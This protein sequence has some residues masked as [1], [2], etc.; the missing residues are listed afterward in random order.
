M[1]LAE[2]ADTVI[3]AKIIRTEG[4]YYTMR[5]KDLEKD[6]FSDTI[7]MKVSESYYK[8]DPIKNSDLLI[9]YTKLFSNG[10]RLD[11]LS[12][13]TFRVLKNGKIFTPFQIENPGK[14]GFYGPEKDSVTWSDFKKRI[15]SVNKRIKK[16]YNY[17]DIE[18]VSRKN[19]L[20]IHWIEQNQ[21]SFGQDCGWNDDC[22]WGFLEERVFR[23]ISK[24]NI[25]EDTWKA[26]E[27]Y[28]NIYFERQ[29]KTWASSGLMH[30]QDGSSFKAKEDKAFLI[31]KA[32]S[33]TVDLIERKQ[34]L[35]FLK[36]AKP[37]LHD[38]KTSILP[39]LRDSE[40][41]QLSIELINEPRSD[42]EEISLVLRSTMITE[43]HNATPGDFKNEIGKYLGRTC[44]EE[45][46][47]QISGSDVNLVLYLYSIRVDKNSNRLQFTLN[48]DYNNKTRD[49]R[50]LMEAYPTIIVESTHNAQEVFRK[51]L[52]NQKLKSWSAYFKVDIA[53]LAK[54]EYQFYLEGKAGDQAQYRW[55]SI[56][57]M[58]T[59]D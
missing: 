14:V 27:L 54:G 43:Y 57:G 6:V 4:E 55:K 23:W 9:V 3:E 45:A 51:K 15:V 58:F 13:G 50:N 28:R 8:T 25:A 26:A 52:E 46:W 31:S 32:T 38:I 33:E 21:H 17:N 2:L 30:D 11:T 48:C 40:L 5:I 56:Q 19:Q 37:S 53:S 44:T 49:N 42:E 12:G 36:T 24:G 39:L 41:R 34:A 47:K 22:G 59:I 18:D 10:L 1:H 7:V 16:I 29:Q 35:F 20:L